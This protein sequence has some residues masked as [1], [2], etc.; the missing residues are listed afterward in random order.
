MFNCSHPSQSKDYISKKRAR[1]V[2]NLY[3]T[4]NEIDNQ[5]NLS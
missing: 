4:H 5:P 2:E 3:L 1:H